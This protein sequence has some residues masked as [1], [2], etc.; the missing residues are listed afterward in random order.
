MEVT[1][2]TISYFKI[3]IKYHTAANPFIGRDGSSLS[4]PLAKLG[5]SMWPHSSA[6]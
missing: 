1:E 5:N 6:L 3:Y 2:K 4:C